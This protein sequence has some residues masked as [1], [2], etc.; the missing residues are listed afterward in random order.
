[1]SCGTSKTERSWRDSTISALDKVV[2]EP[3]EDSCDGR[4]LS[5]GL[6]ISGPVGGSFKHVDWGFVG[7]GTS[8]FMFGDSW[9][10]ESIGQAT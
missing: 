10:D 6:Q 4:Q 3:S 9:D 7:Q 2:A 5:N 8:S 1:M